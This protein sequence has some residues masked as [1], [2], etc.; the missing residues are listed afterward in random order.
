[1]DLEQRSSEA[2][3]VALCGAA[4]QRRSGAVNP[5]ST[6]EVFGQG[7]V[8]QWGS[9]TEAHVQ[10]GNAEESTAAKLWG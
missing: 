4:E 8:A 5:K 7:I 6:K 1:M 10:A 2:I 9:G 3:R